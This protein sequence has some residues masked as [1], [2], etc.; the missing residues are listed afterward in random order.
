MAT[1]KQSSSFGANQL[2]ARVFQ[3]YTGLVAHMTSLFGAKHISTTRIDPIAAERARQLFA[4]ALQED[5]R[6]EL[7]WLWFASKM[8]SSAHQRYCLRRALEINPASETARRALAKLALHE[9]R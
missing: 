3:S 6:L 7:D 1:L 9:H 2:V 5:S 4:Q 8:T